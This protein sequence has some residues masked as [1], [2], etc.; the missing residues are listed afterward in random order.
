VLIDGAAVGTA[1]IVPL[2]LSPGEHTVALK[3]RTPP[4]DWS[5]RV[6]LRAGETTEVRLDFKDDH[7]VTGHVGRE[8]V[9]DRW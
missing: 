8:P 7:S 3:Q 2:G 5:A 9:D 4:V 6:R 1:P